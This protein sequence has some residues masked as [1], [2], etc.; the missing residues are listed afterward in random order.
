[1]GQVAA[2]CKVHAHNGIAGLKQGK[3][4]RHVCLCTGMRLNIGMFRTKQFTGTGAGNFFHYIDILAAAVIAFARISFGIF[5]GQ[6]AAHSSHDRGG[7]DIFGGNEFQIV[8]L[9][10][11]FL[12][13]CSADFRIGAGNKANG[14]HHILVHA[15]KPFPELFS[16]LYPVLP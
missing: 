10:L 8:T 1:M 5:V 6:H 15:F 16:S 4:D 11:K 2:F 9:A 7:N 14:V 3:I 13:H 12:L